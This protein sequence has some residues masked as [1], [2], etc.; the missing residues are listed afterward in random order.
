MSFGEPY[1]WTDERASHARVNFDV[2]N[3]TS[4]DDVLAIDQ[5]RSGQGRPPSEFTA[6]A[7]KLAAYAASKQNQQ[8]QEAPSYG[9]RALDLGGVLWSGQ[10]LLSATGIASEETQAGWHPVVQTA[11]DIAAAPLS[12]VGA[13][14]VPRLLARFAMPVAARTG[15]SLFD[16]GLKGNIASRVGQ[17]AVLG[18]G[19]RAASELAPEDNMIAQMG[20]GLAGAAT[21]GVGMAGVGSALRGFGAKNILRA[22]SVPTAT[23][24][25]RPGAPTAS[26]GVAEDVFGVEDAYSVAKL[27]RPLTGTERAGKATLTVLPQFLR[28]GK[29]IPHEDINPIREAWHSTYETVKNVAVQAREKWIAPLRAAFKFDKF[30]RFQLEIP[31]P[32][33]PDGI[34]I[35]D[36][37]AHFP[38]LAEHMS[39]AQRQVLL[40]LRDDMVKYGD[41]ADAIDPKMLKRGDVEPD[42][43]Y[44]H[45]SY[46]DTVKG[47]SPYRIPVSSGYVGGRESF[48][49]YA[50]LKSDQ[51]AIEKYEM[52]PKAPWE[53]IN[54]Y[55]MGVGKS[56][57]DAIAA[58][59]VSQFGVLRGSRIDPVLAGT[60]RA[61]SAK[62]SSGRRTA[63]QQAARMGVYG[64]Q[65]KQAG[66]LGT[67]WVNELVAASG[68]RGAIRAISEPTLAAI[69]DERMA[70]EGMTNLARD[71][72]ADI[73]ENHKL[74]TDGRLSVKGIDDEIAAKAAQIANTTATA[75]SA[76]DDVV[77]ART[78]LDTLRGSGGA[79]PE[80][81][82]LLQLAGEEL[83]QAERAYLDANAAMRWVPWELER[84]KRQATTR[85][86]EI[87]QYVARGQLL[88]EA[89]QEYRTEWTQIRKQRD[90]DMLQ[91]ARLAQADAEIKIL[92]EV[93]DDVSLYEASLGAKQRTQA[94]RQIV[95]KQKLDEALVKRAELS[96]ELRAA[97][98]EAT[99]AGQGR[100]SI[101]LK[102]VQQYDF[103]PA[104]ANAFNEVIKTTLPPSGLPSE[105]LSAL[106][107]IHRAVTG[108]GDVSHFFNQLL[109]MTFT[110]P[111][112]AAKTF[113]ITLRA[114]A[115][116]GDAALSSTLNA[117]NKRAMNE[118]LP[119]TD[120]WAK[121]D[122][123]IATTQTDISDTAG[124][125]TEWAS[126]KPYIRQAN[127][128]F[129]AATTLARLSQ[130]DTEAKRIMQQ[131]GKTA[132]ELDAD[133]TLKQIANAYNKSTGASRQRM[134]SIGDYLLYAPRFFRSR[135]DT[136]T[137]AVKGIRPGA[138]IEQRIARQQVLTTVG[139]AI[140]MTYLI[141][142][143]LGA[144]TEMNPWDAEE[145]KW[146]SR[147]MKIKYGNH[148]FSLLGPYISVARVLADSGAGA[149]KM[150]VGNNEGMDDIT[151]AW[152]GLTAGAPSIAWD[153]A[154][155]ET[156]MGEKLLTP[157][158]MAL[159]TVKR[160]IPFGIKGAGESFGDTT[161]L[162]SGSLAAG[163]SFA[164][165]KTAP[166]SPSERVRIG[167]YEELSGQRQLRAVGAQ[168]W[169][170]IK[171]QTNDPDILG[172]KS[173]FKWAEKQIQQYEE[174]YLERG[175]SSAAAYARAQQR[176]NNM[177]VSK[178]Y[179]RINNRLESAWIRKNPELAEEIATRELGFDPRDRTLSP[180]QKDYR[181]ISAAYTP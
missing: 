158:D 170:S 50:A 48:E 80:Q 73:A 111:S 162:K 83:K 46:K 140:T 178:R 133:G 154:S 91:R 112:V 51:L 130:A 136:M 121:N 120:M 138:T 115:N 26:Y 132:A 30:Y 1:D 131:T 12:W 176:V 171:E 4:P 75:Q 34:T 17:E 173:Y 35:Q 144:E 95:T 81:A 61:L 79:N 168:A 85:S 6:S 10:K 57:N 129:G 78:L 11:V 97:K 49:K 64:E 55:V 36:A 119:S 152:R 56:A 167:E 160:F 76:I 71:I 98:S 5:Y 101:M 22:P 128:A 179:H 157:G 72:S 148:E 3:D 93:N 135:L 165:L 68:K 92:K 177:G 102:E 84:L 33:F 44:L 47:V 42:G 15:L 90:A 107:N 180:T 62:I 9:Q 151:R 14:A 66:K 29:A 39:E 123:V 116:G 124:R 127:R 88:R 104:V 139:E 41:V 21:A 149:A 125:L 100:S 13:A 59:L 53:S 126:T 82:R 134:G 86:G 25:A 67:K 153:L 174:Y 117:F 172:A 87:Q 28:F 137:D 164:G 37:A 32:D 7:T 110:H 2:L 150:A 43:F 146:N 114:F 77:K 103:D 60:G 54:E 63:L 169:F 18:A 181:A 175:M 108:T 106:N 166:M 163:A 74:L 31:H 65:L 58:D 69:N 105:A 109:L 38:S 19:F 70:L 141:N 159:H 23:S 145:G 155:Q 16:I 52:E 45:R 96:D 142:H 94:Q 147:F 118:G 8:Q 143:L 24:A 27:T 122:L 156:F 20:A 89:S 113:G 40:S 99:L 161:D